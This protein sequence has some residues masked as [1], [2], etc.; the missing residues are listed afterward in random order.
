MPQRA[1]TILTVLSAGLVLACAGSQTQARSATHPP[2]PS[3]PPDSAIRELTPRTSLS[4]KLA[5]S[6]DATTPD[7]VEATT[8]VNLLDKD[9]LLLAPTGSRMLCTWAHAPEQGR[10]DLDCQVIRTAKGNFAFRSSYAEG[11]DGHTGLPIP[12]AGVVQPGTP[13]TLLVS[14]WR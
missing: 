4:A 13:F 6:I 3:P 5:T 8:A 1:G 2:A 12:R 14:T 10:I 7:A 11:T 9:G